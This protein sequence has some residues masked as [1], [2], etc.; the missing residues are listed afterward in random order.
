MCIINKLVTTN[1][2]VLAKIFLFLF[3]GC[4]SNIEGDV[5]TSHQKEVIIIVVTVLMISLAL[6]VVFCII[7]IIK[8]CCKRKK[9][10]QKESTSEGVRCR[11][12]AGVFTPQEQQPSLTTQLSTISNSKEIQ[13]IRV[14]RQVSH[15]EASVTLSTQSEKIYMKRT[16]SENSS[17]PSETKYTNPMSNILVEVAQSIS[18]FEHTDIELLNSL[19]IILQRVIRL[20]QLQQ[21]HA[22]LRHMSIRINEQIENIKYNVPTA[23][24]MKRYFSDPVVGNKGPQPSDTGYHGL[25]EQ[26]SSNDRSD[27]Y[28]ADGSGN[29]Q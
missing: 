8:T 10:R 16:T 7:L 19:A 22:V 17:A 9:K 4:S 5:D 6:N 24:L 21:C 2:L 29:G 15:G 26:S 1:I 12:Q 11:V 3:L 23:T 27:I 25:E 20:T 13:C 18:N 28:V 14:L